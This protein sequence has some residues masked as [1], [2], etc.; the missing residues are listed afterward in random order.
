[1]VQI[2]GN[3]QERVKSLLKE[4][5]Q[6]DN[7]DLDF[8]IYRIMN[9]KRKEIE[10]F[11]ERGLIEAAEKQFREYS[12]V[13]QDNVRNEVDRLRVEIIRDFGA[14]TIDEQGY[15]RKN[16]DAPKIKEYIRKIEELKSAEVSQEQMNS[17]F[18][19]IYE[20]FSRYYDKGDF[21]SKRRYGGRDKYYVPYNGEEVVL[22][23]ANKD[24]YYVKTDEYFGRY[25]FRAGAYRV[26][27]L[28][29]EAE[30]G[31]NNVIGEDRF[32]A[33]SNSDF[34]TIDDD[35]KTAYVYFEYRAL[36]EEE[37]RN[38]GI[39]NVQEMLVADAVDRIFSRIGS[40]PISNQLR[41]KVDEQ[42]TT[43]E[44][45]LNNYV[46]RNESDYF[47]HKNLRAFLERE[48]EFYVENEVVDLDELDFEEKSLR[49][50]RAKIKAIREISRKI[51]EFL[52][53]IE[54]FQKMLF[55]KKKFVVRT[56]F[57][58][59]LDMIPESFYEEIGKNES[60]VAEWKKLFG[61]DEALHS[62]RGKKTLD[63]DFLKS[64]RHLVLDT[65]F[66]EQDFKDKVIESFD[67]LDQM[68]GG[69]IIKSENFQA[70]NLL[71]EKY[72]GKIECL[73]ID[74]PFNTGP[75]EILYKNN[76]KNS[77]WLTLMENRFVLAKF[78][79]HENAVFV[80]AIDDYELSHLCELVD[81]LF[82]QYDRSIVVVN[83]HPQG[84]YGT[85]ITRTHEYALFMIPQGQEILKG[86]SKGADTEYRPFM[87]SG[88]GE[89]NFR[90]GR[91]NSFYAV[92]VDPRSSE[93]KGV[94]HPPEINQQYSKEKTK[95]GWLRIYPLG[96]AETERVW[97]LS[98][99]GALIACKNK[100]LACQNGRTIYQVIEHKER[101]ACV[102]SNWIDKRYNAGVYGTN[103][104]ADIMGDAS[105]FSYPKSLYTVQ[106]TIEAITHSNKRAYVLDYFAGS[107]TTAHAT[108]S[109]NDKDGGMR[110]YILVEMG[111]YF[112][113]VLKQRIEKI[114]YSK[115][116]KSGSP[117][118]T[119]GYSHMFKYVYLE[120][121]EDTLNNIAFIQK[122]KTMQE[123]L[124]EFGDYL[125]RYMLEF[126]TRESATRLNMEKF[127]T[128]FDYKI[129]VTDN[130]E[131]RETTVDLVETFNY[132]LGITVEKIRALKGNDRVYRA[133]FG[134][135]N[136]EKIAIIWRNSKDIDLRKDKEFIENIILHGTE[137]HSI[138]I[139]SDN[140]VK[141]ARSIEPEFKRL[142]GA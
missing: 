31:V 121:Y 78:L 48:L 125:L 124:D 68:I 93:V 18:N 3:V 34:V 118:S 55:E 35:K 63:V 7:Q 51:I 9:F 30:V 141:N 12:F 130:G 128:P 26:S 47:I 40:N 138:F 27:F 72:S 8:G 45:H 5:F 80:V 90:F 85:N 119:E 56:D 105:V 127:Q 115:E 4:L 21:I 25:T 123:T 101:R 58:I 69:T 116:W 96:R 16:E 66:F 38:F 84:G 50:A 110:K 64:H 32:F 97:R 52:S 102:F 140:Y 79:M 54:D 28:L 14:G 33:L 81:K 2:E 120:Q 24:Q 6:F 13:G 103:L 89:N 134:K 99:E 37:R 44:K 42:G 117:V 57:C 107:G 23:W 22:H 74:P 83:H 136:E 67:N 41:L 17:V 98:Y 111:N 91:P 61:L 109:L 60:Q 53:H 75:T 87:R 43:L 131:K 71:R 139:N 19:H 137:P 15:V 133:I 106:D 100:V 122:D 88:R 36:M 29:E 113:T 10:K 86:L 20:F 114:M 112:E 126:E 108:L 104:I 46:K 95:E 82:N 94:E 73:Y 142:M 39:R 49:I 77:S 76:Y 65:M 135:K 62:T 132:L 1:M 129:A 92:L 70:L 11:I 59:T